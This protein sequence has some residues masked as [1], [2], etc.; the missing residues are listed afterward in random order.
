MPFTTFVAI[1]GCPCPVQI[2]DE[3]REIKRLSGAT[4]VSMYR[5]SVGNA[6]ALLRA[7]GKKTQKQLWLMSLN[8]T[9]NPAN[10][11]GQSTHEGFNDGVAYK[12]PVGMK[13]EPWQTGM[14]W[15][16]P[17][18][19]AVVS[20]AR[21]KKWIATVT[22]PNSSRERQHVN[23]RKE[24]VLIVFKSLKRGALSPRVR[25]VRRMLAYV[26]DPQAKKPY[27][28]SGRRQKG[29]Q[30]YFD[31]QMYHALREY[32]RDHGL[33][34]DGI[35]GYRTAKQLAASVRFRKNKDK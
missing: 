17:H 27:L 21:T 5:G 29:S 10:R 4:L 6:P 12:G 34:D 32:Q 31:A 19:H 23:F 11:P 18:V 9:G 8:G 16:I 3:I 7:N 14:D 20:A 33:K 30:L 26:M 24:P 15:D 22:Y 35:Y 28:L 13:L 1:D 25:S 2:A